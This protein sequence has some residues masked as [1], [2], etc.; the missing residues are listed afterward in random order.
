LLRE[1][2]EAADRVTAVALEVLM[3]VTHRGVIADEGVTTGTYRR[4]RADRAIADERMLGNAAEALADMPS[5]RGWLRGGDLSWAV[6]RGVVAATRNLSHAQRGRA[7]RAGW[8]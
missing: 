3:S 2:A 7:L 4:M 6:V 8:C 1:L 5:L